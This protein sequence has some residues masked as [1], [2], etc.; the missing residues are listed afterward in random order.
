MGGILCKLDQESLQECTVFFRPLTARGI[1][2]RA[3]FAHPYL[4]VGSCCVSIYC[5]LIKE[6]Y[7]PLLFFFFP[8]NEVFKLTL[9]HQEEISLELAE[10]SGLISSCLK[11]LQR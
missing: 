7:S 3:N 8:A 5:L 4:H 10:G 2:S 9:K 11:E 6:S 1:A